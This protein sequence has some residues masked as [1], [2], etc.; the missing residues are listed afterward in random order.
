MTLWPRK[1]KRRS[2]QVFLTFFVGGHQQRWDVPVSERPYTSGTSVRLKII[3]ISSSTLQSR[4]PTIL[5]AATFLEYGPI[6]DS[7]RR[8]AE[9]ES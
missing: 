9:T 3:T 7:T 6:A 8:V 4:F 5:A 1:I 2:S